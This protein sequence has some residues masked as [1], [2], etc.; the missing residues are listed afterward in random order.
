MKNTLAENMLRFGAKNLD[1]KSINRLQILAEQAASGKTL[2]QLDPGYTKVEQ[3][4]TS[5]HKKEAVAPSIGTANLIYVA[6]PTAGVGF[7]YGITVYQANSTMVDKVGPFIM[8]FGYGGIID[9]DFRTGKFFASDKPLVMSSD[10]ATNAAVSA[11]DLKQLA[12]F[13][14]DSWNVIPSAAAVAHMQGRKAQL[15]QAIATI[16][17]GNTFTTLGA[18][19]TGT[20]KEIYNIIAA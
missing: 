3:Y 15:Q 2:V 12:A 5:E 6:A 8:P 1:A 14:N 18:M 16:K 7:K 17:M 20:A 9:F 10:F 13:I 11:V 4:F 19:L